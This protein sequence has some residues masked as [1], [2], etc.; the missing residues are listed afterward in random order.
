[1][2]NE[3]R[4]AEIADSIIYRLIEDDRKKLYP[5]Y[6]SKKFPDGWVEIIAIN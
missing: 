2:D 1:M 5:N 6:F 4:I 3:K